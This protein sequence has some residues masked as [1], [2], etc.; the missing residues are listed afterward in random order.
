MSAL[1]ALLNKN[2]RWSSQSPRAVERCDV[3]HRH[4]LFIYK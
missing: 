2:Q 3:E 4:F 1:R